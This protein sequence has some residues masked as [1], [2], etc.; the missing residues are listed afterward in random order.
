MLDIDATGET[1]KFQSQTFKVARFCARK[2]V[3]AKDIEDVEV[4][5]MRARLRSVGLNLGNRQEQV[6]VEVD[7]DLGEETGNCAS[8]TGVSESEPGPKPE[9]IPTP[10]SPCPRAELLFP[11]R[12]LG[13]YPDL[14]SFFGRICKPSQAPKVNRAQYYEIP[15][16]QLQDECSQLGFRRKGS[17]AVLGAR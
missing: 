5:P 10:D 12:F 4:D 6:D 16:G 14:K 3:G 15:R 17:E 7:M 2:K 13:Q 1:V 9:S 11:R 8:S